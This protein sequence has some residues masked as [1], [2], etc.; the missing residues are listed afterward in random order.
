[1]FGRAREHGR[2]TALGC[3]RF[4]LRRAANLGNTR[5]CA[6]RWHRLQGLRSLRSTSRNELGEERRASRH[7]AYQICILTVLRLEGS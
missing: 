2:V 1:M 7:T 4:R 5:C 3:L 6:R